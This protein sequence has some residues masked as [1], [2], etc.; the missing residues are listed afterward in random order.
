MVFLHELARGLNFA[1]NFYYFTLPI[2][3]LMSKYH[4]NII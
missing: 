4:F 1:G 2:M 3:T